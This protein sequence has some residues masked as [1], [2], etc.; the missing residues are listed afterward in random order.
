MAFKFKS[1]QKIQKPP[2]TPPV[3]N[4]SQPADGF[5]R[6]TTGSHFE[7]E[8][9]SQVRAD[10]PIVDG[11]ISKIIRLVGGF[12]VKCHDKKYQELLNNFIKDVP[13]NLTGFSLGSFLESYLDSLLTYGKAVGEILVDEKQGEVAGLLNADS[14]FFHVKSGATPVD[15]VY[16]TTNGKREKVVAYPERVLFTALNPSPQNPEGVSILRGIPPLADILMKIYGC[17]GKNFDRVGNVRYAVTYKPS[18]ES[19]GAFSRER[20]E[21]IAK[22]WADGMYSTKNGIVKDF[23]AVGDIDIKVIGAENQI[24]DSETPARQIEEQ[25]LSKL[26]IPPFLLGLCW[27]STERMSTQ[28]VDILTSELE[29]YRRL[30]NPVITKIIKTYFEVHQIGCGFDIEWEN[31]NLQDECELAKARYYNAQAVELEIENR[32]KERNESNQ[33]AG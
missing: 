28:Q 14:E 12:E 8:Q 7:R 24:L 16:F 22:E 15:R 27:S 5:F 2:L 6:V 19:D 18:S 11:A 4:A 33:S 21:M 23:V 9:Y 30:L 13:V 17:I 29:Y 10:L 20:A 25:I 1:R 3:A 32:E 31:I 26:S